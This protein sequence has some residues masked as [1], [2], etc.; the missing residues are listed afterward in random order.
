MTCLKTPNLVR[1]RFGNVP[2]MSIELLHARNPTDKPIDGISTYNVIPF[3][4]GVY[5]NKIQCFCFEEQRLRPGE[6][7]DMPVFFYID[8]EFA[9]DPNM[10]DVNTLTLSYTFFKVNEEEE[11]DG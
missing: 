2:K 4:A 10:K 3:E 9:T 5:F 7:I 1:D 11:A 6:E 8:R